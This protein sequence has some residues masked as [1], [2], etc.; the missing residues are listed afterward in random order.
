M[1]ADPDEQLLGLC[2]EATTAGMRALLRTEKELGHAREGLRAQRAKFGRRQGKVGRIMV[3]DKIIFNVGGTHMRMNRSTLTPPAH[4]LLAEVFCG[5]WDHRFLRDGNGHLFLDV[6]PA[7]F[8][9]VRDYLIACE[10]PG[11]NLRAL[12]SLEAASAPLAALMALFHLH[13][14]F[15]VAAAPGEGRIDLESLPWARR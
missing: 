8:A 9:H 2:T 15:S 10:R 13:N 5:R 4:P 6:D 1:E 14:D 3:Q 11:K 12:P 7:A